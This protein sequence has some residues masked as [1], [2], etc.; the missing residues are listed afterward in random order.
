MDGD[1]TPT[2]KDVALVNTG[3][4]QTNKTNEDGMKALFENEHVL[5]QK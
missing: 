5:N 4:K 3:C 1:A 2:R